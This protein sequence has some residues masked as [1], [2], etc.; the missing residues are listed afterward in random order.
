MI[1]FYILFICFF[2]LSYT[3]FWLFD[4]LSFRKSLQNIT[5]R[6]YS[7]QK[8]SHYLVIFFLELHFFSSFSAYNSFTEVL[9]V[10]FP[11]EGKKMYV[12]VPF[13]SLIF[14]PIL[15]AYHQQIAFLFG[16]LL[17]PIFQVR[18]F[19]SWVRFLW[20]LYIYSIHRK[21]L[22]SFSKK[23]GGGRGCLSR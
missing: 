11:R 17:F 14:L 3:F 13:R 7:H 6:F 19:F 2:F 22:C 16:T 15:I 1:L 5:K 21:L 9:S 12:S 10:L 23:W 20:Q 4:H 18:I 8:K